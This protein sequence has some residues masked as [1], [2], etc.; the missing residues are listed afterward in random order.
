[1]TAFNKIT[2]AYHRGLYI[3]ISRELSLEN[4]EITIP[5]FFERKLQSSSPHAVRKYKK[6]L[7]QRITK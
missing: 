3:D 5:S 6:H 2:S 4:L 1:M 7:K